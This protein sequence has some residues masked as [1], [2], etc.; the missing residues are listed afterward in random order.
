[1]KH[2]RIKIAFIIILGIICFF[3][4][5][6][7]TINSAFECVVVDKFGNITK[8]VRIVTIQ[9][10]YKNYFIFEDEFE[11]D[12][13]IEGL[14]EPDFEKEIKKIAISDKEASLIADTGIHHSLP[15][16]NSIGLIWSKEEFES[17]VIKLVA[18]RE[19]KYLCFPDEEVFKVGIRLETEE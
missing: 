10:V 7:K 13:K 14:E 19:E 16:V 1:M 17:F 9:G 18:E 8:E 3:S 11:G 5:Y 6:R 4:F 2:V 12:I 15:Q